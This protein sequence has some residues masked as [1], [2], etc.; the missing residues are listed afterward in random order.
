MKWQQKTTACFWDFLYMIITFCG[1]LLPDSFFGEVS[2]KKNQLSCFHFSKNSGR[3]IHTFQP[4]NSPRWST[5]AAWFTQFFFLK[6]TKPCS[7]FLKA[8]KTKKILRFSGFRWLEVVNA[9]RS[10]REYHPPPPP[11]R[12]N[13]RFAFC[14]FWRV[15]NFNSF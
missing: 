1:I 9:C 4:Q 12:K 6:I 5:I 13:L 14:F 8:T 15:S 3:R 11:R 2:E 7:P 10:L